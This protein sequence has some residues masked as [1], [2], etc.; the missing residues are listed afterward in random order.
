MPVAAGAIASLR[1]L[2]VETHRGWA[3]AAVVEWWLY[4]P[5]AGTLLVSGPLDYTVLEERSHEGPK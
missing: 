5:A 1:N 4:S 3:T 2:S